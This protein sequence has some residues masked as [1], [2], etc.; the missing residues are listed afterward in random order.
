MVGKM[1]MQK[2]GDNSHFQVVVGTDLPE[3]G[4]RILQVC[5]TDLNGNRLDFQFVVEIDDEAETTDDDK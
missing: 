3:Y 5:P 4:N 2:I 1:I